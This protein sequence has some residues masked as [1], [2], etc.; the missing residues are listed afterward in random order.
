MNKRARLRLRLRLREEFCRFCHL[1]LNLNLNLPAQRVAKVWWRATA[2]IGRHILCAGLLAALVPAISWA[3][4]FEDVKAL[5]GPNDALL[6]ADARGRVLVS[7]NPDSLL[8]PA[9]TLKIVT[10]LSA[11][12]YLGKDYRFATDFYISPDNNLIIKGH[13]DP[14][15]VSEQVAAIARDLAR[16]IRGFNDLVLDGSHFVAPLDIPST[17]DWP[18][19]YDT[20]CGAISVNFNTVNF[21]THRG[22]IASAE[23]QTPLLP[24]ALDTIRVSGIKQ[25]RVSLSK[26]GHDSTLYAGLLF[27]Y[28][29]K[30]QGIRTNGMVRVGKMDPVRDKLI[31][32]HHAPEDLNRIVADL[33][34]HSNNFIANQL[35]LATGAKVAGPPGDLA[36]GVGAAL[37]LLKPVLP[38]NQFQMV[39]GSGLSRDNRISAIAMDRV[40]DRFAPHRHLMKS[41]DRAYYKTG[42]LNGVQARAGYIDTPNQPPHRFVVLINTPGKAAQPVVES[43][44]NIIQ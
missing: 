34:A 19:P 6:V 29:L 8:M 37:R 9:S 3:A 21:Q 15:L 32:T 38:P 39:E 35:L 22:R 44:L 5:I 20:P 42:T 14:I 27:R 13:G 28:F 16:T 7:Q 25:G 4:G 43:L 36:K 30:K 12:H 40:L 17:G 26:K 24:F 2:T 23:P 18:S 33:L 41:L 1:N 31:Y 11:L 10:A